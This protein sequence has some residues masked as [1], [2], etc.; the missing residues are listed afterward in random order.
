MRRGIAVYGRVIKEDALGDSSPCQSMTAGL[1]SLH[2][3]SNYAFATLL[4]AL[5]LSGCEPTARPVAKAPTVASK[6]PVSDTAVKASAVDTADSPPVDTLVISDTTGSAF[7]GGDAG[8]AMKA[9]ESQLR[10]DQFTTNATV[11]QYTTACRQEE[12][13][14]LRR[15]TLE[16]FR[17]AYVRPRVV[18]IELVGDP[19]VKLVSAKAEVTR[20]ALARRD[21]NGKW[22]AAIDVRRDTLSYYVRGTDSGNEWTVCGK[23]VHSDWGVTGVAQKGYSP[24]L[25]INAADAERL[26]ISWD[27]GYTTAK[28]RR[29]ADSISRLPASYVVEGNPEPSMPVIFKNICPGEGCSFGEW[30]TC[31]TA[32]VYTDA[33]STAATAFMLKRGE[34]FTTLSGDMHVKRAGMIVFTRNTRV[35]GESGSYYFTPA[36]TIYPLVYW[37]EGAGTW[38]FRGKQ[39]DA[40]FFF[41]NGFDPDW[42]GPGYDNVRGINAEWWVKLRAKDGREGWFVPGDRLYGQSPHYEAIPAACPG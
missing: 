31:D 6:A 20:L 41:G 12:G 39:S 10:L 42:D 33:S 4:A 13:S 23:P 38:Y 28:L 14:G 19:V 29:L 21:V 22:Q 37:G 35:T 27:N 40:D 34:R 24:W 7:T 11:S 32:R 30:L 16:D 3:P 18:K 9:L 36:D 5:V 2:M 15:Y 26:G 17:I 25:P 1:H 8:A